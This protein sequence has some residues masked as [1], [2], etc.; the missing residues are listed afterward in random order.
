MNLYALSV[1]HRV[2]PLGINSA[3][4]PYFGWKLKSEKSNTM[5]TAYR[6]RIY[7][8]DTV[9]FDSG[10]VETACNAFVCGPDLLQ[11]QT[12]YR[13]AVTVWDNHGENTTAESSFETSLSS[14]EW[15]AD[16]MRTPRAYVQRKKGFGTQPPATLFRRAFTLSAA[17]RRAR[18]YATCLGVYRLTVNGKRPDMREF[19]PEHTSYKGLLCFQTYDLTA[20]LHIG[21]NVLGMEVGDGWYCCPQTQP[22]IDGLQPDHTVLFQLEIENADGTHPYL[23]RRRRADTRERCACLGYF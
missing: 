10:R 12:F 1:N 9:C 23:L 7:A 14:K 22:P 18:L 20:L 11:P 5:Q 15:K 2:N 17:P 4:Q 8:D 6:L 3:E 16:W 19:A 21:E 13:W